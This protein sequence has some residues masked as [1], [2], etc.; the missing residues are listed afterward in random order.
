MAEFLIDHWEFGPRGAIAASLDHDINLKANQWC[1]C[2]REAKGL[3]TWMR[4]QGIDSA[5]IESLTA[6]DTRPRFEVYEDGSFLL[7]LRGVNLNEG[8]QADDML[9]LRLYWFK[10]RL[11]S[12]R[13][14]PSRA[15][16]QIREALREGKGPKSIALLILNMVESLN[17]NI[18]QY[19]NQVETALEKLEEEERYDTD[20]L[21]FTHKRL[22]KFKR[23]MKPQFYALSDFY[24]AGHHTCENLQAKLRNIVDTISRINE[25][26][27]FYLEQV[28]IMK[29]D[30]EQEQNEI[31]NRNSYLFTIIAALFLPV[32]FLTGL[33]GINIGGMPGVD[34]P[35]AFGIFCAFLL[36]CFVGEYIL[37]KRLKFM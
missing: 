33:L 15:I 11:I 21:Y 20:A 9:S 17:R 3:K 30:A 37:L 7:I 5:V 4:E 19:L 28:G 18:E 2:Q 22:L 29:A 6:D 27:N 16:A 24:E 14:T 31:M 12:T 10:D 35:W 1:H 36:L 23:F 8:A 13:K 34:S 25:S 32:S 26:I